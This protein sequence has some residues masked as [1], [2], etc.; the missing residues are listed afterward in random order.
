MLLN[1]KK[2]KKLCNVQKRNFQ[3]QAY[4]YDWL[5]GWLV[6]RSADWWIAAWE[7]HY[8]ITGWC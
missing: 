2:K 5:S 7:R 4:Y 6:S 8:G 1:K 3:W